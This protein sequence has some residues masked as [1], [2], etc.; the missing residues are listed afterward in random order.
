MYLMAPTCT[1]DSWWTLESDTVNLSLLV[2]YAIWHKSSVE[3]E[4]HLPTHRMDS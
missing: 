1:R 4:Y 2:T 3:V